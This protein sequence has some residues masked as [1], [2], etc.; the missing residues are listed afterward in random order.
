[1]RVWLSFFF[2]RVSE[3]FAGYTEAEEDT[4]KTMVWDIIEGPFNREDFPQ[5]ELEGMGI[6]D[7]WNW[8]LVAKVSEGDKVGQINLWYD[9]LD[10]AYEVVKYFTANIEPL[11]LEHGQKE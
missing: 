6:P 1:M 4:S 9:T 10:E 2:L 3:W 8:M 11:E 5:E 7:N